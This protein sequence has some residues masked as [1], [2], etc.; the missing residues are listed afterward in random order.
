MKLETLN[1]PELQ[2]ASPESS[3]PPRQADLLDILIV[4]AR[5]RKFILRFTGIV[6]VLTAIVI[7][8]VPNYYTATSVLLPPKSDNSLGSALLGEVSGSSALA[9][10]AGASLGLKSQGDMYVT[11]FRSRTIEDALIHQ[12]DLMK[13][14]HTK[15]MVDT[16]KKFESRTA[17]ELGVKDGLITVR[18]TD[19]DPNFAAKLA[20]TYVQQF[21]DHVGNMA[22]TEA[23]QRRAF[24]QQQ[25]LDAEGKLSKAEDAMKQT[26]QSTG[27][28]EL[29]SQARVLIESAAMLRAQI[30]AKEVELQSLDAMMTRDNPRYALAQQQLDALKAQLARVAGQGGTAGSDVGLSKSSIPEAGIAY[31]NSLRDVRYYETVVELL[32]KQFELAKLEEAREGTVQI[33]DVAVA[34]DK[35]SFPPR[36]LLIFLAALVGFIVATIFA[37]IA[38]AVDVAQVDPQNRERI[39]TLKAAF[40]GKEGS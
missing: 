13:R 29:S 7:F 2:E 15:T 35:K 38:N 3:A 1:E 11:L 21:R 20:N 36:A 39:E 18:V 16:R 8:L 30:T 40:R 32:A 12:F 14:Y 28:L 17:V 4:L 5:R 37:V 6:V 22:I 26:E 31:L 27:V 10:V 34:P 24:F 23:S 19:Y 33:S 9:S 25:L